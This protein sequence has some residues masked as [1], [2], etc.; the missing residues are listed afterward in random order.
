LAEA[1]PTTDSGWQLA[2]PSRSVAL[3]TPLLVEANRPLTG[4]SVQVARVEEHED[5]WALS[6]P[7]EVD[8]GQATIGRCQA[9]GDQPPGLYWLTAL[10]VVGEPQTEPVRVA[11][12]PPLLFEIR[13][14]SDS[15]RSLDRL[16]AA[17]ADV[18]RQRQER[19]EAGIG[20]GPVAATVLV[21]VKDLLVSCA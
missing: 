18:V 8:S 19:R 9:V 2:L 13:P 14:G 4:V 5:M 12:K 20:T 11:V 16:E 15:P 17:Y 3:G 6:A 21:F 7:L 10:D 1:T